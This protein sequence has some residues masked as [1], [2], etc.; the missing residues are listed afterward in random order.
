MFKDELE[1]DVRAGR[2]GNGAVSMRREKSVPL[3]GPDGGDGGDGGSVFLLASPQLNSLLPLAGRHLYAAEDGRP[4]AGQLCTG[5]G[6]ADLVVEVPVGTQVYDRQW[7]NLLRDLARAGMRLEI[8]RGGRGGLGNARFA[9]AVRQ[10]PR[11]ATD[12]TSGEARSLRLELKLFAEAGLLG[13]P[14]AGK[15]TFLAAV[16]AATPKIADYPF[17]TLAPQVGIA[18][19][20]D[21]D[22]LVLADLP[23]LIEGAAEG[24]GLGHRFLRHVE[25]CRVL[26][27]LV[28]VSDAALEE[29]D[30][31]RRVIEGE[32]AGYSAELACRPRLLVA[33]KCESPTAQARADALERAA[34]VEVWRVSSVE[35][36]GLEPLLRAAWNVVHAPASATAA[37]GA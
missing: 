12:G 20:S 29:P 19:L 37:G 8:A 21:T 32:L 6:G 28:D 18:R 2:G 25:R 17:T 23:G 4:G 11:F 16:T 36:R 31:A 27:H 26:L 3:G 34:G 5:R 14:N 13:L 30:R 33:T 10:T 1:I 7:G 22:T 15:S 24:H 9:T 35:R